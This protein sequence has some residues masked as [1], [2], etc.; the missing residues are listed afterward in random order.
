MNIKIKIGCDIIKKDR[1]IELTKKAK[2]LE[3]IFTPFE[4]AQ[5]NSL[6]KLIGVFA[7]KEATLKA[8][9]LTPGNWNLMEVIKQDNGKPIIKLINYNSY[10]NIISQDISISHD[11]EYVFAVVCFLINDTG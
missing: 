2:V 5:S 6:E 1:F 4:I 11:G 8:L 7:V 3:R 10:E 9:E